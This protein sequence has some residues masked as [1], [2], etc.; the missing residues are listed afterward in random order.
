MCSRISSVSV[1]LLYHLFSWANRGSHVLPNHHFM[2]RAHLSP[3]E[4][5]SVLHLRPSRLD[6]RRY[7]RAW[8]CLWRDLQEVQRKRNDQ[9]EPR[10]DVVL[11]LCRVRHW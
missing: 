10:M 5:N 8:Q 7:N 3:E 11:D 6:Y 1:A 2:E 4:T 9:P